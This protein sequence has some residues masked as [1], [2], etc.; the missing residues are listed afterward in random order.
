MKKDINPNNEEL[1]DKVFKI[2]TK[3]K[4]SP[5]KIDNIFTQLFEKDFDVQLNE[6][7][8]LENGLLKGLIIVVLLTFL[9]IK[10][11]IQDFIHEVMVVRFKVLLQM[12]VLTLALMDLI[13]VLYM[14][15]VVIR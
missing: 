1:V 15:I 6:I 10:T 7:S 5:K 2:L 14:Q 9:Y 4:N 13:E 11:E 8:Q 12:L 3:F